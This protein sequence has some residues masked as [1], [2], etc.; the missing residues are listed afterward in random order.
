MGVLSQDTTLGP[1]PMDHVGETHRKLVHQSRIELR[2]ILVHG[3][4]SWHLSAQ[5]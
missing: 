2:A 3:W 4:A 1:K 5:G